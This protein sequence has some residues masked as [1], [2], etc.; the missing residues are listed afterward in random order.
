MNLDDDLCKLTE[1]ELFFF[2]CRPDSTSMASWQVVGTKASRELG[3]GFHSGHRSL[4]LLPTN[5]P[6][7]AATPQARAGIRRGSAFSFP[8]PLFRFCLAQFACGLFFLA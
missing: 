4:L 2:F 6:T 5:D 7:A 1:S 8:F 3:G